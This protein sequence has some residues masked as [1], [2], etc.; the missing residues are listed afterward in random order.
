MKCPNCGSYQDHVVDTKPYGLTEVKRRRECYDCGFRWNT[1]ETYSMKGG[2]VDGKRRE[3]L[4]SVD[5]V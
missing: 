2:K 3:A 5:K 4:S 1:L